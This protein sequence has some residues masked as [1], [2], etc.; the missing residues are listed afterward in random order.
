MRFPK[1]D[2]SHMVY[3]N[4]NLHVYKLKSWAIEEHI[5]SYFATGVLTGASI[6][7]CPM[8]PK[9]WY[10]ANQYGS[11]KRREKVVRPWTN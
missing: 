5:C 9:N 11:F 6:D 8:F 4:F 7:K 2:L 3:P 1:L 10:S